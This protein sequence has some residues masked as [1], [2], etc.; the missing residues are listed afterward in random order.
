M[1]SR[2]SVR[3]WSIGAIGVVLAAWVAFGRMLFGVAGSLT[4]VYALTL[5]V[6]IAALH[7]FVA[8]ASL[9]TAQRGFRHRPATIG[10]LCASWACAALLGLLIPDLTADGL[11]TILTR[12]AEPGLGIAIGFANPLG[13][14]TIAL[15]I[16]A[17][18]PESA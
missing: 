11:Q 13:V 6:V 14:I 8:L 18:D 16:T 17:R 5:G 10:T 7:V 3:G 15:A 1:R 4:P 2:G 9:R 12:G